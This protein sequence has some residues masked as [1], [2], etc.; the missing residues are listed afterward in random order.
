[1]NLYKVF[2][3]K[4]TFE[5]VLSLFIDDQVN[6]KYVSRANRSRFFVNYVVHT[7][8]LDKNTYTKKVCT[9]IE[10]N[11]NST[12]SYMRAKASC[13]DRIPS[14]LRSC[15]SFRHFVLLEKNIVYGQGPIACKSEPESIRSIPTMQSPNLSRSQSQSLLGNIKPGPGTNPDSYAFTKGEC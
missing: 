13:I 4:C 12:W 2:E 6:E 3:R 5:D 11:M 15:V 10:L 9:I 14:V 1:M 8:R 7:N